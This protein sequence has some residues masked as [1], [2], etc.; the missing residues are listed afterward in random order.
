VDKTS[1]N[2]FYTGNSR[3]ESDRSNFVQQMLHRCCRDLVHIYSLKKNISERKKE[4][5]KK[6]IRLYSA[7][8]ALLFSRLDQKV[9]RYQMFF[10]VK[11]KVALKK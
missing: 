4:L 6:I 5:I 1:K 7:S 11:L 10:E 2:S 8:L 3:E 9:L